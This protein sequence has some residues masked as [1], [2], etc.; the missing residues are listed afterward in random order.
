MFFFHK[1]QPEPIPYDA[2]RQ[3]PV[4]QKSICTGEAAAG[5]L[6]RETGKFHEYMLIQD[7]KELADFCQRT[8]TTEAEIRTIY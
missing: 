3:E 6:D 1:P 7:R 8:G 4:V 2:S 5:F